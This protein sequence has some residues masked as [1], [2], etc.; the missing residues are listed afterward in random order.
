MEGNVFDHDR[1][2][3]HFLLILRASIQKQFIDQRFATV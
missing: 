3:N 2:T 1:P